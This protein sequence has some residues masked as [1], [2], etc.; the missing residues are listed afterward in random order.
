MTTRKKYAHRVGGRKKTTRKKTTT[1]KNPRKKVKKWEQ[2][3]VKHPGRVIKIIQKEFGAKGFNKDGTIKMKYLNEAIEYR[4]GRHRS[5]G[6]VD[7]GWRKDNLAEYRA[8]LLAKNF[9]K[10]AKRHKSRKR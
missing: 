6:P 4:E 9:K 3:A 5:F 8:L 10:Q 7:G 2:K 1:R